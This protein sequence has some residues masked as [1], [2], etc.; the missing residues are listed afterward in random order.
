MARILIVY[1]GGTI[2]MKKTAQGY[3]P[4]PGY[5]QA[6]IEALPPFQS[7]GMPA[8]EVHAFDPLLDSANMAPRD[9]LRIAETIRDAY[10]AYDGFL[11]VHGTDTMAFTS[12]AL[13]FMLDPLD[14]PVVLTGS[15][16]PLAETRNDAQGNLLTALLLLEQYAARLAGVFLHFNDRL[17][18][19]NRVT[20]VN[21]DAFAAF[22]SPNVPPVGTA[23]I[24]IE[25]ASEALRPR[26]PEGPSPDDT[27]PA[28]TALGDATVAAFRL[29]PGLEARYLANVLAPPVQG[30]VL[31]CYGSGNA[32]HANTDFLE[33]LREATAR[34]V[35]IVDVTQPLYGTADLEL[36]AT[37]RALLDA[38]VVSGY[39]MTTEAALAKLYYLFEQGHSTD[40][41]AALMQKNLRGELTPP[42]EEPTSVG[43]T[44]RR[45]ARYRQ[46]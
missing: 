36:Y 31:E 3:A 11:V 39:D 22:D 4:V 46:R 7:D 26:S 41:V 19:G 35:V 1:T 20:K 25:I 42:E 21:A 30:V 45:L 44:R 27:A 37:G 16:I 12:S 23:G 40:R 9:W 32:P 14:K 8:F 5:L 34:G 33:A 10:A 17:Y 29:F 18:R 28:V 38:G 6:Q 13:S 15:Q 24:N 2:G 43:K